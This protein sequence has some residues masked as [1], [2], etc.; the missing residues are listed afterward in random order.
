MKNYLKFLN[1]LPKDLRERLFLVISKIVAADL[2]G[3]DIKQ[4]QGS[5]NIFRCRVGKLRII[6][7]KGVSEYEILDLG[8]RGDV[9]K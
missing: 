9:Y 7:R 8:F 5:E 1:R 4:L 2:K 6:F 3:L